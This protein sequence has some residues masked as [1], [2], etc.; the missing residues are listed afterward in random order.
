MEFSNISDKDFKRL[1]GFD[2]VKY[3]KMLEVVTKA[4]LKARMK[5]DE[6][7]VELL[8]AI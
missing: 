4:H 5:D 3:N 1:I 7:I 8:N 6:E 2:R